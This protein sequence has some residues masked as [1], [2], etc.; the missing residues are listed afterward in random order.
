MEARNPICTWPE[1]KEEVT[2]RFHCQQMGGE[3]EQLMA[4][5]QEGTVQEFREQFEAMSAPRYEYT[6]H[7]CT[8]CLC[9]FGQGG[10]IIYYSKVFTKIS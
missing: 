3:Y 10:N 2:D 5:K 1:F 8:K 6:L 9:F 7:I 4:L